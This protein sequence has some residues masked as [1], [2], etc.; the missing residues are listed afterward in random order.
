MTPLHYY[1]HASLSSP[2]NDVFSFATLTCYLTFPPP[3]PYVYKFLMTLDVSTY[4]A[5][6]RSLAYLYK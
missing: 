1:Y 2:P 4:F 6:T 3:P 5:M